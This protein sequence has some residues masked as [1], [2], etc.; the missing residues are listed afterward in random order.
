MTKERNWESYINAARKTPKSA[1]GVLL[2]GSLALILFGIIMSGIS[3]FTGWFGEATT[4]AHQEFGPKAM[5]V[6]YEWFKDASAGLDK[7]QAN[8]LVYS[9]R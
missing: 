8:I 3:L 5:L 4:V 1:F 9:T 7:K 2:K 6:K